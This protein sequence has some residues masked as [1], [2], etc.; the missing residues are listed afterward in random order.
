MQHLMMDAAVDM[1]LTTTAKMLGIPKESVT[2]IVQAGLP[3]MARMAQ[4]NPD[5]FSKM[6]AQSVAML[7]EPMQAYYDK[8]AESPEAQAR[9]ADEFNTMYGPITEALNR[10][11]ASQAGT[12]E[13]QAGQVMAATMPALS[14]AMGRATD[15][16]GEAGMMA[17]LKELSNR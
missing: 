7:P 3:M 1:S 8:L 2:R 6:Y 5:L 14:Q 17:W 11:A 9:A 4:K 12:T 10:E 15:G 16:S 13:S